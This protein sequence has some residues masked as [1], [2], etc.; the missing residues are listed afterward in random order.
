[1][2]F[3]DLLIVG[4]ACWRMSSMIVDE[5]GPWHVFLR[6]RDWV[7]VDDGY[8]GVYPDDEWYKKIF[9]CI[10]CCSVWVGLG[11]AVSYYISPFFTV[12]LSFPLAVSAFAILFHQVIG[13]LSTEE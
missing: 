4:L 12:L 10:W 11:F 3:L 8:G 2:T 1:M 5:E 13:K 9:E 6:V 7:G